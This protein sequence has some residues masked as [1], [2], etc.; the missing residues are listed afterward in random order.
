QLEHIEKLC[1]TAEAW[2]RNAIIYEF[3][4]D[5]SYFWADIEDDIIVAY[6]C[7]RL[8]VDELQINN[9]AVLP[10]YRRQGIGTGLIEAIADFGRARGVTQIQLEVNEDNIGAIELYK[11]CGFVVEGERKNYYVRTRFASKDAYIMIAK[12]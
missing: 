1:F 4:N 6:S 7:A 3:Q 12:L 2:N 9:I 11:K 8:I 10:Q 5:F